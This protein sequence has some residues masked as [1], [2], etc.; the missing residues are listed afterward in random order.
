MSQKSYDERVEEEIQRCAEEIETE[1]ELMLAIWL[2]S[3]PLTSPGRYPLLFHALTGVFPR[4][5][6]Y[7]TAEGVPVVTIPKWA[8]YQVPS[9]N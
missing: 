6:R 7:V 3:R 4:P 9:L 2:H 8:A 1:S 5:T